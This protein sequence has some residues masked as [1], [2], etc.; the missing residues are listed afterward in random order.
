[1][2][3][4]DIVGDRIITGAIYYYVQKYVMMMTSVILR[5]LLLH[6]FLIVE[7]KVVQFSFLT[8][9]YSEDVCAS[10][11]TFITSGSKVILLG[12]NNRYPLEAASDKYFGLYVKPGWYENSHTLYKHKSTIMKVRH[13]RTII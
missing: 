5:F 11:G 12:L 3:R 4:E 9:V 2:E 10:I 1:M 8:S 6:Y 7:S 13:D